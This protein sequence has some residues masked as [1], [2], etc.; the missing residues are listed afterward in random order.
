MEMQGYIRFPCLEGGKF[1]IY[2]VYSNILFLN[3]V[4]LHRPNSHHINNAVIIWI[5]LQ[6]KRLRRA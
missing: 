1:V 3:N 4:I 6:N 5:N 2:T